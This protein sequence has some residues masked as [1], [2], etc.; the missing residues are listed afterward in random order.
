MDL[1]TRLICYPQNRENGLV[2]TNGYREGESK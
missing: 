1:G 2:L